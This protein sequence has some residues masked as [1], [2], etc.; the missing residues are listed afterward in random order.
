MGPNSLTVVA[1]RGK[2]QLRDLAPIQKTI[3]AATELGLAIEACLDEGQPHLQ[4]GAEVSRVVA[5]QQAK[6]MLGPQSGQHRGFFHAAKDP[7]ELQSG[8]TDVVVDLA[9]GGVRDYENRDSK[10]FKALD[11]LDH[12]RV[13]RTAEDRDYGPVPV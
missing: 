3:V 7:V 1:R 4:G 9:L 6:A 10:A 12:T 11:C 8:T 13:W 5:E 2:E